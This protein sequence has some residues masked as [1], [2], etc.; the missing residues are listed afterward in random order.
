MSTE[1]ETGALKGSG[2]LFVEGI[3]IHHANGLDQ[4]LL[5]A[6]HGRNRTQTQPGQHGQH[7]AVLLL[8]LRDGDDAIDAV[9]G[10]TVALEH[11]NTGTT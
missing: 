1:T 6:I 3:R 8:G 2:T 11:W 7:A 10:F 5:R 4:G 9:R